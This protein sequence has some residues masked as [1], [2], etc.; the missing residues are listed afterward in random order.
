[1]SQWYYAFLPI[2]A[3]VWAVCGRLQLGRTS[4]VPL[5]L[6]ILTDVLDHFHR[7]SGSGN[8]L[9]DSFPP[10]LYLCT[11]QR[12]IKYLSATKMPQLQRYFSEHSVIVTLWMTYTRLSWSGN[13]LW[14][15]ADHVYLI[16]PACDCHFR[17][18]ELGR[19]D[20]WA[21]SDNLHLIQA[22]YADISFT[23]ARR[24]R[25][26]HH[27]ACLP[28]CFCYKDYRCLLLFLPRDA[29]RMRGLWRRAVSVCPS[30]SCIVSK[31]YLHTF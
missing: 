8:V 24:R 10:Y 26:I 3:V 13:R 16:P 7:V 22:K 23:Q 19:I 15:Y 12:L 17:P 30:H 21:R 6:Y 18:A 27:H 28:A 25:P 5:L 31:W 9:R 4:V 20:S 1:M 2:I 29:M 14:K 11:H